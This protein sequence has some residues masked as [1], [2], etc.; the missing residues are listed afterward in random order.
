[1]IYEG[2]FKGFYIENYGEFGE[3]IITSQP[4]N[5]IMNATFQLTR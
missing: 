2:E 5:E 4:H 1:M 3:P